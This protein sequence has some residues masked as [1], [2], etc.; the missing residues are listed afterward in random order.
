MESY[1][2]HLYTVVCDGN[3]FCI[4]PISVH[5]VHI[6]RY[7]R[8]SKVTHI[9]FLPLQF[10]DGLLEITDSFTKSIVGF[11]ML[12]IEIISCLLKCVVNS[13]TE[14]SRSFH[15]SICSIHIVTTVI[16]PVLWYCTP[17][18]KTGWINT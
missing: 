1:M 15:L 6:Q 17:N 7:L 8:L 4:C 13:F 2:V 10:I 16:L 11:L 18:K 14:S 12:S 5:Y 9:L 3:K